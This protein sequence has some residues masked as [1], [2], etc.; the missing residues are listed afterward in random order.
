MDDPVP[1][2]LPKELAAEL[3]G[4]PDVASSS[5]KLAIYCT[6]LSMYRTGV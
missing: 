4:R 2:P 6:R 5:T 3:E 1:P